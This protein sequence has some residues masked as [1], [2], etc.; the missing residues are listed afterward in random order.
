MKITIWGA[1]GSIPAP[2]HSKAIEEKIVQAIIHLPEIDLKDEAAVRAYVQSLKPLQ[3]GTAGGN[4]T[5]LQIQAG[6]ETLII[7]AGSGLRELGQELM[8]GPCGRGEGTLHFIFTHAHWDHIQGFPFFTPAFVPGNKLYFYSVHNIEQ[9]LELQQ[10]PLNFPIPLSHLKAERIYIHLEP[11]QEFHIGNVRVQVRENFHPGRSFSFRFEDPHSVFVFATDSEYQDLSEMNLQPYIEFFRNADALIFDAQYTLREAWQKA[12]WGHSSA[13]IGLDLARA[14]RVKHLILYHHDPSYSDDDLETIQENTHAYQ[15]Q[16]KTLPVCKISIGY[17]GMTL[18]LTPPGAVDTQHFPEEKI[19]IL[20]P[21]DGHEGIEQVIVQLT[22]LENEQESLTGPIIDLSN[23]DTLTT[24]SLK[25]LIEL[26][27][28]HLES[29][30]ALVA[31]SHKVRQVI[32]LAGYQD[33]FAFYPSTEAAVAAVR[34]RKALNL[35]GHLIA[36]RYQIQE[37]VSTSPLGYVLKALDLQEQRQVAL[38]MIDPSFEEATLGRLIRNTERLVQLSH[39]NIVNTYGWGKECEYTFLIEEFLEGPTLVK[40]LAESKKP[41]PMEQAYAIGSNLVAALEY[42]H[43]HGVI[44]SGFGP[45]H[46]FLTDQGAK[47]GGL[48]VGHLL[49]GRNLLGIPNLLLPATH[50]SPEHLLGQVLDARTDL[51]VLGI[52]LYQLFTG[53]TPFEGSDAEIKKAHL[54]GTPTAPREYNAQISLSLEHLILRLLSKNPNNRYTSA[55]QVYRIWQ[56]LSGNVDR[57]ARMGRPALKGRELEIQSILSFWDEVQ[58]KHGQLVMVTGEPGVGK[59][60]L[61]EQIAAQSKA[62]VVL[63]GRCQPGETSTYHLFADVLHNYLATIPPELSDTDRLQLLANFAHLVPEIHHQ[64]PDLPDSNQ[65]APEQEQLRLMASL[66]QFIQQATFERPWLLIL[67]NL[68]WADSSSLELFSYLVRHL[69]TMALLIVGIYSAAELER[70]HPLL[71]ILRDLVQLPNYHQFTLD[72][73]DQQGTALMLQE[74][75]EQPVPEDLAGIIH[76]HTGGN[77]FYIEEI[78]KVLVDEGLV[79]WQ[80]GLRRF[81]ALDQIPLPDSVHEVVRRRIK[82]LSSGTQNLL[83]YAAV[84]GQTFQFEVLQE[85]L[86]LSE[87][88]TLEHLDMALERQLVQEIRGSKLLGFKQVEIQRILYDDLSA[89]RRRGLHHLA[90]QV[91][92]RRAQP[93]PERIASELARHYEE[94]GDLPKAIFY[95]LE[96]AH[97]AKVA[98]ANE[99][100]VSWYN[101]ALEMIALQACDDPVASEI[102]LL[103]AHQNIGEVLTLL[104]RYEEALSHFTAALA[105]LEAGQKTPQAKR[106]LASIYCLMGELHEKRSEFEAALGWLEKGLHLLD[107]EQPGQELVRS[108]NC[109]GWVKLRQGNYNDAQKLLRKALKFARLIPLRYEEA[110]SLRN[111]GTSCWFLGEMD[112]AHR[113][114]EESAKLFQQIG[115]RYGEGRSLNNLGLLHRDEGN[116]LQALYYYQPALAIA[117]EI[118]DRVAESIALNNI[119]YLLR[120]LGNYSEARIYLDK[121]LSV[122]IEIGSRQ[123]EGMVLS[124]MGMLCYYQGDHQAALDFGEKA[125][126][127]TKALGAPRDEADAWLCLGHA[128]KGLGQMDQAADAYRKCLGLRIQLEQH[129]LTM[130][131]LAGL[132]EIAWMQ[133]KINQAFEYIEQILDYFQQGTL[134]GND[135]PLHIYWVCY[136]VLTAKHDPRAKSLL[137]EAHQMLQGRASLIPEEAMRKT[138]LQATAANQGILSAW[139]SQKD[140]LPS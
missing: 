51:Y 78:A 57:P 30:I 13:M 43:S 77:P 119:G 101:R 89:L 94:A 61:A 109:I 123:N 130:E 60:R 74:I 113:L 75:W 37:Q 136:Q 67:D 8:K 42:L 134:I 91:L 140:G 102:S 95:C 107:P 56:S 128:H 139:Q 108:Y 36:E 38:K 4:T 39:T 120:C 62:S 99:S 129:N 124:N 125:V 72:R 126:K 96:A 98:Y 22:R 70:G 122:S 68:E 65:L 127:I 82:R 131:P 84:L 121:A 21:M 6:R 41:L 114:W 20:T 86:N 12:D 116:Y 90:A 79:V 45:Q 3:R 9:A 24:A 100:A 10:N 92:E 81:P 34:A 15:E 23:A 117:Q 103:V 26:H 17:E 137:Q 19:T 105:L 85:M 35:P 76:Q 49:E 7:D 32:E 54:E 25:M 88:E 112:E 133:N 50:L 110:E 63:M 16:D 73:L 104:G 132:A 118:G 115:D 64:L 44:H 138:F 83:Q 80:E 14:A 52:T 33:F 40:L 5:C 47:L 135:D 87:W 106:Q 46:I 53:R 59:T 66:T 93:M 18:N 111:L 27:Q 1:R 69:S 48:G 55:N 58:Q 31:P 71:E 28:R 11:D 97:Q 2:I 29:S